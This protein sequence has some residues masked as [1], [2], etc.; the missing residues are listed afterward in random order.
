[1]DR[2]EA[3]SRLRA[4][5]V[6]R[7][8]TVRPDGRPHVVPV[9]FALVGDDDP[10]WRVYWAVD[11]KPKR[12]PELQRLRNISTHDQAELVVDSYDDTWTFL[13]WVRASGT[14]MVVTDRDEQARAIAA[15]SAK[16]RQYVQTAPT[17][18]V[19][20]I[21]LEEVSGWRAGPEPR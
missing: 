9:V 17:G 14:S 11:H 7:L 13:W 21:V 3:L 19:I 2:S 5:R 6:A 1:M 15:L 18:P 8:A 12:S 16:Y 4:A 10:P 20:A